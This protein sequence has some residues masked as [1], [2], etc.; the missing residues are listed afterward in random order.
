MGQCLI[1]ECG[2]PNKLKFKP[3]FFL[4]MAC[5]QNPSVYK[6]FPWSFFSEQ[7]KLG[8]HMDHFVIKRKIKH[9]FPDRFL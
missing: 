3:F 5:K 8:Q 7:S 4:K 6:L 1:I 9:V 2:T